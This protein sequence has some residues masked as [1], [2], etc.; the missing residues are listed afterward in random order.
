MHHP[1]MDSPY[2]T[3][4]AVD[5]GASPKRTVRST[6][7]RDAMGIDYVC[8]NCCSAVRFS[9][10]VGMDPFHCRVCGE[11]VVPR[12]LSLDP[13]AYWAPALP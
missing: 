3:V 7:Y 4:N 8:Q 6:A 11:E 10:G 9:A 12:H 1:K 2:G 5:C 13:W